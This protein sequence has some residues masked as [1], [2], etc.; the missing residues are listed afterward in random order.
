VLSYCSDCNNYCIVNKRSYTIISFLSG[1]ICSIGFYFLFYKLNKPKSRW[2]S[3]ALLMVVILGRPLSLLWQDIFM[4]KQADSPSL[5]DITVIHIVIYLLLPVL[6]GNNRLRAL[7]SASFA[8]SIINITH[9][10]IMFFTLYVVHPFIN[11]LSYVDFLH[12]YPQIYYGG[13]ILNN[14]VILACCSFAAHWLSEASWKP[15]LKIYALFNILFI[16]FPVAVLAWFE[17]ILSLMSISFLS[18]AVLGTFLL[19]MVMFLF[20]LYTRL[21]RDNLTDDVKK[22]ADSPLLNATETVKYTQFIQD[23]SKRELDVIETI[24]AGNDSYKEISAVLN[25]SVHT[26]KAHLKKIYKVTGVS[27]VAALSSL[28]RDYRS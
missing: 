6:L 2:R 13:V 1:L 28:F 15:H 18:S 19:G 22:A 26:V 17:D 24:L 8:F 20:Y 11:S 7:I 5:I 4:F 12:K 14:I 10:P 16:L 27:N 3:I 25:I 23:L 9:L 21:A